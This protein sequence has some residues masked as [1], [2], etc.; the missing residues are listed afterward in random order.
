MDEEEQEI[1]V[2]CVAV[3]IPGE[4]ARA[5]ISVSGPSTRMTESLV[6][7]A[8]PTLLETAR[9]FGKELD[10]AGVVAPGR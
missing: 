6:G 3:A 4:R 2:R 1:G 8:V 7:A 5:A 10:L 9:A